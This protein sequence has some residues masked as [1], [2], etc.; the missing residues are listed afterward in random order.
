MA[1]EIAFCER[2]DS[3]ARI[4][5]SG[6][7]HVQVIAFHPCHED[8][9][10]RS[11]KPPMELGATVRLNLLAHIGQCLY[12]TTKLTD[13]G[14]QPLFV[15]QET[16]I[17]I[18]VM[19]NEVVIANAPE[20][21]S[22]A[23]KEALRELGFE[24]LVAFIQSPKYPLVQISFLERPDNLAVFRI[25][26]ITALQHVS[27]LVDVL[28]IRI[29]DAGIPVLQHRQRLAARGNDF[30]LASMRQQPE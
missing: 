29:V 13:R 28:T 18:I 21:S 15:R 8:I 25:D 23:N 5:S 3:V 26:Y 27:E 2:I 7:I 30:N 10:C 14:V 16:D 17:N 12:D 24:Y 20:Q 9:K 19:W 22:V 1:P 4:K 11:L 6:V